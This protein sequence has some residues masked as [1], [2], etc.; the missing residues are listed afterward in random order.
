MSH[1]DIP[2]LGCLHR[3]GL[4]H[5]VLLPLLWTYFLHS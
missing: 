3:K 4:L 2:S 5:T 1:P